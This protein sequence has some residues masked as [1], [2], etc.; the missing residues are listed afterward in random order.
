[1]ATPT[2]NN[3]ENSLLLGVALYVKLINKNWNEF[4]FNIII[5]TVK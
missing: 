4:I 1:M 2:L 3:W 5:C